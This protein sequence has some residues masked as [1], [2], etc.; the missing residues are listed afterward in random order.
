MGRRIFLST[1][2]LADPSW[3]NETRSLFVCRTRRHTGW[4]GLRD[5]QR[6]C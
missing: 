2:L 1:A 3:A 5:G 4:R 6:N